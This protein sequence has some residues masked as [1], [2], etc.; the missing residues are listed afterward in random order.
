MNPFTTPVARRSLF[1]LAALALWPALHAQEAWP[2]RPITLIHPYAPG[3]PADTLARALGRQLEAR[4]KQP[5]VVDGRG[6]GAATIGTAAVARA[7]PDGYTLL[8][9]TSAGHVVTPLMQR[10]AYDGIGDFRFI[11]VV[12]SQ[13]N[14]LVAHPSL[15]VDGVQDLI[16]MARKEP[17]R[18]N[19]ASAGMGGATHLGAEAFAQAA[20]I[21]LTH[22]P[23]AGAAP[24]LKDLVGGQVQLGMLNLSATKGFIAEGK[25]KAL[26]YGGAQ[27]TPLLPGVPTL[28][29]L[30]WGNTATATW[31]TLA[32]P[33]GTPDRVVEALRAAVAQAGADTAYG[34]AL[35]A[36]GAERMDLSP[37]ETTAFVQ[38]DKA[39]MSQLLG[40]L[41]LL[42]KR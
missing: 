22:V 7:K 17:G 13:P 24:A 18:L 23:Y 10:I 4:L 31:Y 40:T 41:G 32:A 16:A 39:A 42:E 28:A 6:G 3:G 37:Q 34:Q 11:A 36:L 19:Y 15:G 2:E 20:Q 12:A 33:K 25:L 30:G 9:G 26:A 29:E 5:V 35:A 8:L 14:V 38:R 27:R 1:G 21:K